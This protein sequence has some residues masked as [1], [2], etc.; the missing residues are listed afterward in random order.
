MHE[1]HRGS[2]A[3]AAAGRIL[4]LGVAGITAFFIALAC[5]TTP[6][7]DGD[8]AG[9]SGGTGGGSGGTG[10][11]TGGHVSAGGSGGSTGPM[12]G[13]SGGTATGG[14]NNGGSAGEGGLGG[15]G[16]AFVLE[17]D[18][19]SSISTIYSLPSSVLGAAIIIDRE[20]S[21]EDFV[22][23]GEA[24]AYWGNSRNLIMS[25]SDQDRTELE[26][27]T[28]PVTNLPAPSEGKHGAATFGLFDGSCGIEAIEATGGTITIDSA[29]GDEISGSYDLEFAVGTLSGTFSPE[30]C[31]DYAWSDNTPPTT[32][33]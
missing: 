21:C 8:G 33:Y 9:G 11:G 7:V 5:T 28:Y 19:E 22:A 18:G 1:T 26:A 6:P 24:D 32:C 14:E 25:F 20:E 29:V 30:P 15:E 13:G 2:V 17:F 12:T 4:P 10:G 31:A 27:G 16:G 3:R 23:A